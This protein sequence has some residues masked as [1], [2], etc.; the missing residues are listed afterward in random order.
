MSAPFASAPELLS[1]RKRA[2][3][4]D[5]CSMHVAPPSGLQGVWGMRRILVGVLLLLSV[6]AFT[7]ARDAAFRSLSFEERVEAQRAIERVYYS[8][9][10]GAVLPFEETVTR[11]ILEE[12]VRSY[13]KESAA[14][15]RIWKRPVT[16]EMLRREA[17]RIARNTRM[18]ERLRQLYAALGNDP[19]F[20][21][22]CLARPALVERLTRS[23]FASDQEI[24]A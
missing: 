8:H 15:D 6:T 5:T 7:Q 9:Q 13:L 3:A 18:P 19:F 4:G 16:A 1:R 21:L 17:E 23:A 10:S 22:E 2:R 11:E 24:H 20:I 14:L 12:K